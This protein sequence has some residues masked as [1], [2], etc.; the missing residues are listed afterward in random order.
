M[1]IY[2]FIAFNPTILF[3]HIVCVCF[4]VHILCRFL[5]KRVLRIIKADFIKRKIGI[6]P[7]KPCIES[8]NGVRLMLTCQIS[9]GTARATLYKEVWAYLGDLT[10]WRKFDAIF[11]LS[12]P[13]NDSPDIIICIPT[14]ILAMM[15]ML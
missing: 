5:R 7:K 1:K 9:I 13:G 2:L 3:E 8:K 15:R 14:R 10:C 6:M 4:N 12:K 11:R